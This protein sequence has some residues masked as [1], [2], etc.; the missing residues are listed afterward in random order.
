[1]PPCAQQKEIPPRLRET[2]CHRMIDLVSAIA[3]QRGMNQDQAEDCAL[4]FAAHII[5][6][7]PC[8]LTASRPPSE[9]WFFRCA[10]NWVRNELRRQRRQNYHEGSSALVEGEEQESLLSN[11]DPLLPLL[12]RELSVRLFLCVS[13]LSDADQ[14]LFA[15]FYLLEQSSKEIAQATGRT[16]NAVRQALWMLR[17]R[18]RARLEKQGLTEAESLDYLRLLTVASEPNRPR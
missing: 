9:A 4:G 2:L 8:V 1:M 14:S 13:F 11:H 7:E 15:H 16:D 6:R 18:L 10:A 12:Q 17:R 5:E 3:R